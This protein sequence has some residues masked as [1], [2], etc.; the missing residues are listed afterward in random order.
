MP[1]DCCE[2]G[3]C[4]FSISDSYVPV[5]A[6]DIARLGALEKNVTRD[7]DG[8]RFLKMANGRCAQL[9]P[10]LGDWV[11]GIYKQRPT[12]CRE[13]KRGSP[14]CLAERAL[15]RRKAIA[16]QKLPQEAPQEAGSTLHRPE[17]ELRR[18]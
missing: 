11:C 17:G 16:A 7:V 6:E 15:K 5:T 18:S 9:L 2:C 3:A 8:T 1:G 12:A 10:A 14:E 4:C 13:L